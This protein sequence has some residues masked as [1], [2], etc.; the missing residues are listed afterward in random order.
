MSLTYD[1]QDR[2]H[3]QIGHVSSSVGV[4]HRGHWPMTEY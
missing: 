1:R 2:S 4:S 3:P